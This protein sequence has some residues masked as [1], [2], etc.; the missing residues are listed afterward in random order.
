MPSQS[1][2][3]RPLGT[4]DKA[5]GLHDDG[6]QGQCSR[7]M[8]LASAGAAGLLLAAVVPTSAQ[9]RTPA[10]VAVCAAFAVRFAASGDPCGAPAPAA[11]TSFN[12]ASATTASAPP[13]NACFNVTPS[14]PHPRPQSLSGRHR[15]FFPI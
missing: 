10:P 9:A 8:V 4:Q 14:H 12:K 7:R 2:D 1:E 15:F 3:N 6:V 13:S 5:G 11:I